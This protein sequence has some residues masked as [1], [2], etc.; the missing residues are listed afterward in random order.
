MEDFQ[1]ID[2]DLVSQVPIDRD[3][4]GKL[5]DFFYPK[6]FRYC[7]YRLYNREVA[8]DTTSEVFLQVA[9]NIHNFKDNKAAGFQ[10]WIYAITNNEINAYIRK[11]KRREQLMETACY[12]G[13]IDTACHVE[14]T[15]D[16]DIK[17]L[18]LHQ[19]ILRLKPQQQAIITLRFFEGMSNEDIAQI[20]GMKSG[21]VRTAASRAVAI[22]GRILQTHFPVASQG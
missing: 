1:D 21:A 18:E 2:C 11:H 7:V 14:D 10:S 16:G 5:Y 20:L 3:S 4:L 6:I 22:L 15:T 9:R 13:K 19:A 12:A 17:W 8:E